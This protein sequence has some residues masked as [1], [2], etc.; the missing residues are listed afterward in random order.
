MQRIFGTVALLAASALAGDDIFNED[1]KTGIVPITDGGDDMFY[2]LE[3]S[4]RDRDTDPLVVWLTGGPG[5][6]SETALLFENGGFTVETGEEIIYNP[7]SWSEISNIVFVDNPIGTGFS[8][9]KNYAHLESTEEAIAA[10]LYIWLS[11]FLAENPEFYGRDFYITGESYAGHYLPSF[12]YHLVN[13]VEEL[14]INFK[15]V[16]IGNG[17]VDPYNQYPAYADFSYENGLISEDWYHILQ[18]GFAVCQDMI[19]NDASVIFTM[20]LCSILMDSVL[21]NPTSPNFNVYDIRIPC[22]VPPLCYDFS[23]SAELLNDPEVQ[24][25]LGVSGRQWEDCVTDVHTKLLGDWVVSMQPKVT[26]VLEAGVEVLVYSGD[27]DFVCNWRGGE[28]WTNAAEWH[29]Q[30]DFNQQGYSKWSVNNEAAGEL[31]YFENFKFLRVYDAG[32]MV[33]K[34]Q[35]ERSLE[36]LRQFI[37]GTLTEQIVIQ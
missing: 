8:N 20:D 5:C 10:D 6:A 27:K 36:M 4:R 22:D 13:N 26:S 1:Y 7:Y 30:S 35:P 2:W 32:H 28:A 19:A 29:G 25:L 17:W 3:Y 24:E 21:G 14:P 16:A 11:G 31:K 18:K 9:A 37:E 23:A 15:G 34:D 33:P 12:A